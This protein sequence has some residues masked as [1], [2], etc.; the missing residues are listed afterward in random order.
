V[1]IVGWLQEAPLL[2]VG[3][4]VLIVLLLAVEVGYRGHRWIARRRGDDT[5]EDGQG[6]LL[7]A[8]LGLLALLLGFTF[9]LSLNRYEA[10][11]ELVLQEANAIGTTYLRSQLLE[12][13]NRTAVGGLLRHYVDARLAWSNSDAA[14]PDPAATNAL[15]QKLWAATGVAIRT[16]PSPQLTRGLMDAMNDSFDAASSRTAAREAH[17]PDRVLSIL[18]LYAILSSVMLGYVLSVSGR[19]HRG[20]T[21][22]MLVLLTLALVVILDLDRPRN[23]AIQVS[24][25]PLEDLKASFSPAP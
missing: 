25:R 1:G 20:A 19:P 18:L 16:D 13:P 23:G 22:L 24:Q 12:E 8:V 17:I 21:V 4:G 3:A 15:Q 7:S 9:S 11:R 2:A 5:L 14:E 10:R 6:H